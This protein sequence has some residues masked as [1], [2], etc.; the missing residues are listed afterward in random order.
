MNKPFRPSKQQIT[1]FVSK[2]FDHKSRKNGQWL[3]ICCPFDNDE[4][5][6]FGINAV[7]GTCN[8]WRGNDWAGHANSKGHRN[9]G[10]LNF[11][12]LYLKCTFEQAIQE[13]SKYGPAFQF[14]EKDEGAT[15]A[16][17]DVQM[18]LPPG[19]EPLISSTHPK[20][21][22]MA[23]G[24]LKS[25]GLTLADIKKYDI[26][27]SAFDVIWPYYEYGL[28]VYWQA[29]NF[30][31][32][33]F[34]FPA[35]DEFNVGKADF[36]YNFD[37]IEPAEDIF[38]TESIIGAITLCHQAGATGGAGLSPT[39]LNKVS[40]LGPKKGVVLVPDNDPPGIN[41]LVKDAEALEARGHKVYYSLPPWSVDGVAVKDWNEMYT[42]AKMPFADIRRVME[43]G[44]R[45]FDIRAKVKLMT[46]AKIRGRNPVPQGA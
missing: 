20:I 9:R 7:T 2:H 38:I 37:N 10:F 41:Y 21:A 32:K 17:D 39:Q 34:T 28:L 24:W 30:T 27:H 18:V 5:F 6:K 33:R 22:A 8:Y 23:L 15:P 12:K 40:L 29:R 25:R 1:N 42:H 19:T 3:L 35:I 43:A 13:L 44:I 26:G 36:I 11:V 31:T 45:K 4:A 46:E 16:P 14:E